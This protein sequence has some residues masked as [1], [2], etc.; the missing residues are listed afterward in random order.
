MD[1]DFHVGSWKPDTV[2][3]TNFALINFLTRNNCL[4]K[5]LF[6]SYKAF[7]LDETLS[8]YVKSA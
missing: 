2:L 6:L 7:L 4:T 3:A 8:S 5:M 1:V